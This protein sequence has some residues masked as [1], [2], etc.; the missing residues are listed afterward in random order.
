MRANSPSAFFASLLLHATVAAIIAGLSLYVAQVQQ[1][2]PPVIFDLVAGPPTAPDEL[3]AAKLGNTLTPPKIAPPV[4]APV[5]QPEVAPEP[6]PVV[7]TAK[8]APV[9]QVVPTP[10]KETPKPKEKVKEAPKPKQP[11]TK[12][13]KSVVNEMNKK[14]IVSYLNEK[15]KI[16]R[17]IAK[18]EAARKAAAARAAKAAAGVKGVDVE[19]IKEGVLGGST[20]NKRGGGGGK[21]LSREE[22]SEML[23]YQTLLKNELR[24]IFDDLKPTGLADSLNADVSFLVAANGEVGNVRLTRSSGNAEFDQAVLATFRKLVWGKRRPDGKSNTW[25]LTFRMRDLD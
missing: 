4:N 7:E 8:V 11:L 1:Q 5:A 3:V 25:E 24:S 16:D 2:R 18:Q 21:A 23:V 13:A 22:A 15:K 17:E 10:P 20:A 19:G 14:R 12:E 9:E 6:E